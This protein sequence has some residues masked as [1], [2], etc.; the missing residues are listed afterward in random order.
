M[1]DVEYGCT[2]MQS[3]VSSPKRC[4]LPAGHDGPHYDGQR[5][6]FRDLRAELPRKCSCIYLHY[7]EHDGCGNLTRVSRCPERDAPAT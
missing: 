2:A 5:T 6:T 4:V 7:V 1:T 3:F